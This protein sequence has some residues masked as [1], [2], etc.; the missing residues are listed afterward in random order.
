MTTR[1]AAWA[2]LGNVLDPELDEPI[3]SLG[4]VASLEVEDGAVTAELRLPT[5]FCAPNFV[6][7]M[8]ADADAELRALPGVSAVRVGVAG[9]FAAEEFQ[10]E[11]FPDMADLRLVFRR[12]AFLA[13]QSRLVRSLGWDADTL[14]GAALADVPPSPLAEA[15]GRARERLGLRGAWLITDPGGAR[16]PRDRLARHL[17]FADAVRV[18][19]EGN[20]EHCRALLAARYPDEL[21]GVA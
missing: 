21:G 2:A 4:F 18:S 7:M 15:Y 8:V 12:K 6:H 19:I 1:H 13:A 3:T 5:Y 17:R 11:I 20:A 16:V 14:A 9:H 10:T